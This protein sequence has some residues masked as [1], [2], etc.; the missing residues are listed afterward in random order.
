MPVI[1]Q[2]GVPP[3]I[4]Q[5]NAYVFTETFPSYPVATWTLKLLLNIP[6]DP[7]PASFAA[8]VAGGV[9]QFTLKTTD[10]A[11][12]VPVGA[13]N[14]AEYATEISSGQRT[15]AATGVLQVIED[16]TKP[17]VATYAETMVTNI[18]NAI[19]ALSTGVNQ[20]VNF[21]GQSFTKKDL[22][23]LQDI[24][25][26]W[27]AQVYREQKAQ[28]VF[29]GNQKGGMISTRFVVPPSMQ[30]PFWSKPIIQSQ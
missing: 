18:E 29:R 11:G 30:S 28:A 13:Y 14:W 27:Q 24:Y 12:L 8:V 21:A 5:G 15:T 25:T 1:T 10:T 9:F 22:N 7:T 2:V 6:G 17:H 23:K 16:L 20:S 26:Y 19:A 4:E 3:I